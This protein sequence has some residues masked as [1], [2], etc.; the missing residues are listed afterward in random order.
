M[1]K[2]QRKEYKRHGFAKQLASESVSIIGSYMTKTGQSG[3]G[4]TLEEKKKWMPLILAIDNKDIAFL[5][6]VNKYFDTLSINVPYEGINLEDKLDETGEP[7][8]LEE[9]IKYRFIMGHPYVAK[10]QHAAESDEK[11][12][13]YIEDAE[14][15]LQVKSKKIGRSTK[16][17]IELGKLIENEIKT[18][19][20]LRALSVKHTSIGSIDKIASMKKQEKEIILDEIIKKDPEF[21]IELTLDDTLEYKAEIASMVEAGVLQRVGNDYINGTQN[22][23]NI[24]ATIAFFKNPNESEKVIIL[25]AKLKQ[26]GKELKREEKVKKNKSE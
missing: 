6:E 5:K 8:N 18:D 15:E 13:F 11:K 4:L 21:F 26:Y 20:I 1:I 2:I 25:K 3:C 7:I 23:G 14:A 24:N 17:Y 22:L 10:D 16:A 9:Y 12:L 19:W